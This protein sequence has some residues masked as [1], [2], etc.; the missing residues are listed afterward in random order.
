MA[1]GKFNILNISFFFISFNL[2]SYIST[3]YIM[4]FNKKNAARIYIP[5][6]IFL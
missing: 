4:N 5:I 1:T 6:V 3:S 2:L